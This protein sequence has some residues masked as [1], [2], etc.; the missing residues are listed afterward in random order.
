LREHPV[1][2]HFAIPIKRCGGGEDGPFAGAGALA[3]PAE[4]K[5]GENDS[6]PRLFFCGAG[7]GARAAG[8]AR[9]FCLSTVVDL[10]VCVRTG[11]VCAEEAEADPNSSN[12]KNRMINLT[13]IEAATSSENMIPITR[14]MPQAANQNTSIVV[15]LPPQIRPR[16]GA[17]LFA[18]KR[19]GSREI[20]GAIFFVISYR[21]GSP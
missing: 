3:G 13:A 5:A 4:G 17:Q 2:L 15:E 14:T 12:G 21:T 7:D 16:W 8:D 11:A 19:K 18:K 6:G 10:R 1:V 20:H 9:G